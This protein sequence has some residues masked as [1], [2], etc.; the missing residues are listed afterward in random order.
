MLARAHTQGRRMKG[1]QGDPKNEDKS[2]ALRPARGADSREG[3]K[4]GWESPSDLK[5]PGTSSALGVSTPRMA[6][7]STRG[8]DSIFQATSCCESAQKSPANEEHSAQ[9]SRW[10]AR[11]RACSPVT[12]PSR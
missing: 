7:D 6:G 12:S 4:A 9:C 8:D 5:A 1:R 3:R 10:S 2:D 11:A